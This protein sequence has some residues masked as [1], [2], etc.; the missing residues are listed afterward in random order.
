MPRSIEEGF[1]DFLTKLK[2]IRA[3]KAVEA[4]ASAKVSEAFDWW[5]LVYADAFPTYYY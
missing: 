3:E 5:R 1:S 4:G 2:A